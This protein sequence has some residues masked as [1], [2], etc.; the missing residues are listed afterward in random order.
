MQIT[1]Y[2]MQTIFSKI[3]FNISKENLVL[4][5]V[6]FEHINMKQRNTETATPT[7]NTHNGPQ[8][9]ALTLIRAHNL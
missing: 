4:V 6:V 7:T 8:A 3:S 5:C 1:V 2:L 9:T